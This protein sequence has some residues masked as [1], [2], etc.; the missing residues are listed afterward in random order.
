LLKSGEDF[1]VVRLLLAEPETTLDR[2]AN[3]ELDEPVVGHASRL[4]LN[5]SDAPSGMRL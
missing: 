4:A 5:G 2:A 1:G 3:R